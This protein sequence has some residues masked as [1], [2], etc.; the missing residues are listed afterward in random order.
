VGIAD[1]GDPPLEVW[2]T[3]GAGPHRLDAGPGI[4]LD[5]LALTDCCA[6]WRNAGETK[7]SP[8]D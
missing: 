5:S 4:E 2:L 6:Y 7:F 1:G 8:V 3:D